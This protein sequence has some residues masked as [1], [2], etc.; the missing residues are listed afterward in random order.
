MTDRKSW[1]FTWRCLKYPDKNIQLLHQH[2]KH[3]KYIVTN[4]AVSQKKSR[5]R[6]HHRASRAHQWWKA[7]DSNLCRVGPK[8]PTKS[9]TS[10]HC[11]ESIS[12]QSSDDKKN[13]QNV[14]VLDPV[15]V[16]YGLGFVM[17]CVIYCFCSLC[18]V[19]S[20]HELTEI[21]AHSRLALSSWIIMRM[22]DLETVCVCVFCIIYSIQ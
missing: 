16:C 5:N 8:L 11:G 20:V 13:E 15:H 10:R 9:G 17:H 19:E 12:L 2:L 21:S 14:G 22:F 18:Q 6:W 3:T 4:S 1:G 7:M